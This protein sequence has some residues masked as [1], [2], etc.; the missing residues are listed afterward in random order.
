MGT[1]M[2]DVTVVGVR[3]AA[4]IEPGIPWLRSQGTYLIKLPVGAS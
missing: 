3:A 1:G 2:L 4:D